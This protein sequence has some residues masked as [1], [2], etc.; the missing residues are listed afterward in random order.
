MASLLDLPPELINLIIL[1]LSERDK[2]P[3][4]ERNALTIRRP[5]MANGHLMICPCGHHEGI[6]KQLLTSAAG[7]RDEDER[8]DIV[9][10]GAAHP[11][12]MDCIVQLGRCEMVDVLVSRD[13]VVPCRLLPTTTPFGVRQV[14]RTVPR[15]SKC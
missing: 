13:G 10:F 2:P 7:K 4:P 8:R 11:Y 14:H 9:R 1:Y 5:V 12:I 15:S 3:V 6:M